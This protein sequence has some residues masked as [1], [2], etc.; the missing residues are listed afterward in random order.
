MVK[1]F[2]GNDHFSARFQLFKKRWR[3][4]A[5]GGCYD[6]RI[7]RCILFVSVIAVANL[8]FYIFLSQFFKPLCC[9]NTKLTD[10]LYGIDLFNDL[11]Q[12]GGLIA[13]ACT[14]L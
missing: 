4:V 5:G 7:I 6:D 10:H 2:D 12:H 14:D 8:S 11:C 1:T 3:D 13:G 9:R